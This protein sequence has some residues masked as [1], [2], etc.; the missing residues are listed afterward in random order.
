V[1][2][3]HYIALNTCSVAISR[4]EQGAAARRSVDAAP[5]APTSSESRAAR[6]RARA[7]GARRLASILSTRR[8]PTT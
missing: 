5:L 3:D 7:T 1:G 4:A 6:L 8:L 2:P